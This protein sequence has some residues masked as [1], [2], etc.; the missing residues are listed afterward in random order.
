MANDNKLVTLEDLGV[1]Y[2]ALYNRDVVTVA[3]QQANGLMSSTDKGKLDGIETG[4]QVNSVTGVKGNSESSYRTGNV[5]LT[6]A[7]VGAMSLSAAL[8]PSSAFSIP[9]SG[10]SVSYNLT[11][12]TTSHELIRWNFSSSAENCPPA[13]L[14]WNT[15][16]GYFTIANNGGTTS[17]SIKP[18]F[19]LPNAVATTN[20]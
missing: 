6:A 9:A 12:I 2:T 10:G 1:A 19:V 4:A 7:N 16:N 8:T 13:K 15:Y 3:T 20:H 17:E 11:G 14:S 18:V 5:N